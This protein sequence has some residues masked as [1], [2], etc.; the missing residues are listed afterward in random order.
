MDLVQED[1]DEERTS[2]QSQQGLQRE[3]ENVSV[4]TVRNRLIGPR[5]KHSRPLSEALLSEQEQRY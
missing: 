5:F 3:G 1:V 4:R 2:Q